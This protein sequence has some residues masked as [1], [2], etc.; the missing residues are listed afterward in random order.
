V[1][2]PFLLAVAVGVLAAVGLTANGALASGAPGA[3]RS[4]ASSPFLASLHTVTTLGP[5][6]PS[7]GDVNP[8]GLA[9]VPTSVGALKRGDYLVSNFNAKSNN[10]GTGTTIAQISAAGKLSMFATISAKSLPGA[11]P[12]GVGLTTALNILPGGYVVVGSL[13]TT[14]G[15]SATA[16][17]GCLIVVNSDGHAVETI[18]GKDIAGPWDMAA[19]THGS[20][21][22]L[23]VSNAL[24]GGAKEGST[25]RTIRPSCASA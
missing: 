5:T 8:Y 11:C 23:F 24:N 19:V 16:R 9:I 25:P 3:A 12:G 13:P 21:T 18:A 17:F 6:V 22:S 7:N 4:S 20:D 14:N 10:Q 2:R 15:L 1:P